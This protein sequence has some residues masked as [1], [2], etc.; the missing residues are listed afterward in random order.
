M[1][2]SLKPVFYTCKYIFASVE[3]EILLFTSTE[4]NHHHILEKIRL[5]AENVLILNWEESD[6]P[7]LIE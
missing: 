5:L 1:Q 4:L 2:F 3:V 7:I 6:K